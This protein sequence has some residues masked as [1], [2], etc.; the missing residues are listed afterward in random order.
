MFPLVSNFYAD[1]RARAGIAPVLRE[2]EDAP[3]ERLLQAVWFHQRLR[4]DRLR[5]LDGRVVRV[6]HPGF[7]NREPGPDFR[8]AVI[9]FDS[10]PARTGDV[11]VDLQTSGWRAHGHDVNPNFNG[12]ALHVVW[13]AERPAG[14]PTLE[15]APVLDAPLPELAAWLGGESAKT[16]PLEFLGRC[17]APLRELSAEK[18]NLLLQQ[19]ALVRLQAKAAQ[20][21]A[22]AK[23]AGW[24]QAL[25]EGLF[26]AL[27]Y[28]H[29]VWPMQR[30]GELRPLLRPAGTKVAPLT[31]QAR[32]LG[33][34]GL[35]PDELPRAH[36]ATDGYIR[37]LWDQWWR[38][39]ES[40]AEVTL[41][42]SLWKFSGLR[43]ANHPQRRLGLA[44]HWL[45]EGALPARIEAWA[46]RRQTDE[47]LLPAL[48]EAMQVG[49]D[50]FWSS[51]WT[52]R[53]ARM[54]KPQPLLGVTRVT[55]LAV[56]AVLP[57]LW[58]R[59]AEGRNEAVRAEMERRFF[60]WPCA[61]DNAVLKLA[62]TRLLGGTSARALRGA[63][64]QQGLLQIVRDFCEHSNALCADCRFPDLVRQWPGAEA[65]ARV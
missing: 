32:M 56:N 15:L 41:P 24:E 10:E 8:N 5:T 20:F 19:A 16:L 17:C 33:V 59:A 54:A 61:E 23:E 60:A 42:R 28:K 46:L 21:Q 9:Q 27:G 50:E 57:W 36:L 44:A 29:N 39:R 4:R 18:L 63:A 11:E 22:R 49:P 53:A 40:L 52:L 13:R 6:L 51:H 55:D 26:R 37:K 14:L 43:P 38:E 30:L 64:A 12:V 7:W 3:P 25:W 31:L 65:T 34:A 35:L 48:V 58:V 45:A 47:A 62:R 1:W 2:M